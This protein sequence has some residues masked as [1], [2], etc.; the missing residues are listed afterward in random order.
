MSRAMPGRIRVT[1]KY[2]GWLAAEQGQ[3]VSV[4]VEESARVRDVVRL[5]EGVKL[6]ELIILVNGSPGRPDTRLR[7][8]DVVSVMPHISGGVKR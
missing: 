2:F 7:D 6:E 8:G 1:I 4:E 5:P 3:K